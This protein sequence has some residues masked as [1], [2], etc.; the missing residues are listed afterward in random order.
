MPPG[1]NGWS[2]WRSVLGTG[3]LEENANPW[4]EVAPVQPGSRMLAT[5]PVTQRGFW[6]RF[7]AGMRLV[8]A[9]Y[10]MHV[11]CAYWTTKDDAEKRLPNYSTQVAE[12]TVPFVPYPQF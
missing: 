9:D 3:V 10:T 2:Q 7:K 12:L 4:E 11:V 5:I 6:D 1:S 8:P